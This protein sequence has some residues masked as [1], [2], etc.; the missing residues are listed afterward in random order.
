MHQTLELLSEYTAFISRRRY[1]PL[2]VCFLVPHQPYQMIILNI[3]NIGQQKNQIVI[4]TYIDQIRCTQ[5][6]SFNFA[7]YSIFKAYNF[8]EFAQAT[9]TAASWELLY[10][11]V[12]GVETETQSILEKATTLFFHVSFFSFSSFLL[13]LLLLVFVL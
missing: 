10:G 4:D 8:M 13:F 2:A 1:W 12:C 7:D 3:N 9:D 6:I 11:I 5:F